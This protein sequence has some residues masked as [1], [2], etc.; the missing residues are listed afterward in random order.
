MRT[1]RLIGRVHGLKAEVRSRIWGSLRWCWCC[2]VGG[3]AWL[4]WCRCRAT[5]FRME[6]RV[7]LGAEE[8]SSLVLDSRMAG[9]CSRVLA[10]REPGDET[11]K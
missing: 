2:S 6:A 11:G 1:A 5:L 4:H 10:L 9:M 8:V 7:A 3:H